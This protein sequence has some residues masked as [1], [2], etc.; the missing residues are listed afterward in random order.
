[1]S[2]LSS[3]YRSCVGV[4]LFNKE[5]KVFIGE[6]VDTPGSWQMPQG[7]IDEGETILVAAARELYEETGVTHADL[8]SVMKEKIRYDIPADVLERLHKVWDKPYIGQEQTWV[9]MRYEGADEEIDL[10]AHDQVEFSQWKWESLERVP[11]LI[12][13]FKRDVYTK[14]IAAFSQYSV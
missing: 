1:M 6:R 7:G 5:G 4:A 13:P 9:A 3:L 12:V 2:D 8:L 14:V 11:D 10:A